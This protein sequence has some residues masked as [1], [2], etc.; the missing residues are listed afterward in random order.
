MTNREKYFANMNPYDL[1]C[2]MNANLHTV[3]NMNTT[4][5]IISAFRREYV[6]ERDERCEKYNADCE[7][8]LQAWMNEEA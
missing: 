4:P 5:C 6:W 1:L 7:K 3:H 8:C 2:R